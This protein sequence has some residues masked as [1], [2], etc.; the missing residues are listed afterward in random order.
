MGRLLALLLLML[1]AAPGLAHALPSN[2]TWPD[3]YIF[4]NPLLVMTTTADSLGDIPSATDTAVHFWVLEPSGSSGVS[5]IDPN[6]K[7][8]T[9]LNPAAT[10]FNAE[11]HL[12]GQ[13]TKGAEKPQLSVKITDKV[14]GGDFLGLAY[15]GD[16]WVFNDIG[17]YDW[18]MI[19]N[20]L[21]FDMQRTLGSDTGSGAWAPRSNYFEMFAVTGVDAK[22]L[23]TAPTLDQITAGY[24]GAYL[25]LEEV[26]PGADRLSGVADK[27]DPVAEGAVGGLVVQINNQS[28]DSKLVLANGNPAV[29]N[30]NNTVVVQWPEKSKLSSG[31]QTYIKDWYYEPDGTGDYKGWAYMFTTGPGYITP[32]G[33]VN[34]TA[35]FTEADYWDMVNQ[36]TDLESFAEYFLINEVAKDPDGYHRST[37]MY[38][39]ADT[40][41]ADGK[42]LVPGKMYAGPMWDKNKSYANQHPAYG[43][44][45]GTD[46][47]LFTTHDNGQAP[48]W[49][50]TWAQNADFQTMVQDVWTKGSASGGAFDAARVTNFITQQ[51]D[52]LNST[53]AYK[54]DFQ[55]YYY[56]QSGPGARQT[57][58][59]AS[60]LTT[61]IT[62]RLQWLGE[63]VGNL[64][65]AVTQ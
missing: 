41:A 62:A 19:R 24:A 60:H 10:E 22:D 21:T 16:H 4:N 48:W 56:G 13:S 51:Q 28:D 27:Y 15:S 53:G 6:D 25:N 36:Y 31:Q 49:W 43:D 44:Y 47:W 39:E 64:D 61:W 26:R 45:D 63:N 52:Y 54:R 23:K 33:T 14:K 32:P 3:S 55:R 65:Q 2:V 34:T 18:T 58:C 30:T 1:L 7:T 12:R 29:G 42:T 59:D 5:L 46:G 40:L 37:Y 20:A 17:T 8:G 38:R 57:A 35:K 9:A 11:V 50:T